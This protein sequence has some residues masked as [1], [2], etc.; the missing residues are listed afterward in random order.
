MYIYEPSMSYCQ[1]CYHPYFN[2]LLTCLFWT[3]TI[4]QCFSFSLSYS[5]KCHF[6]WFF[7]G[8]DKENI[9]IFLQ[10]F[11]SLLFLWSSMCR[12]HNVII[13]Q[14]KLSFFFPHNKA[15]CKGENG[16]LFFL[17]LIGI[18]IWQAWELSLGPRPPL[19]PI[20]IWKSRFVGSLFPL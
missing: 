12:I 6:F 16:F 17:D 14:F 3:L 15:F 18:Q 10:L 1:L 13:L 19:K 5:I 7:W 9:A 11:F 4:K 2:P 8:W 20:S